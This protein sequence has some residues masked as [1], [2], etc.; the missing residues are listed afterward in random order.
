MSRRWAVFLFAE[1]F[2]MEWTPI[3]VQLLLGLAPLV[4]LVLIAAITYGAAYLRQRYVWAKEARTVD[5]VEEALKDTVIALQQT[6]VDELKAA[7]GGKLS[8]DDAER[9]KQMALEALLAKLTEG[10]MAI[11]Q[12][13]TGDVSAWLSDKLERVLVEHKLDIAA[14]EG[15]VNPFPAPGE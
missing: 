6:V 10:Q 1:V 4:Q 9:I 11:L 7:N 14:V 12:A 15:L 3:I 2:I 13:L 5:A 8:K